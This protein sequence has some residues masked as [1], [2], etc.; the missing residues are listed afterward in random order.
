[1]QDLTS[2]DINVGLRFSRTALAH[3]VAEL[4]VARE[5]ATVARGTHE[6]LLGAGRPHRTKIATLVQWL[7]SPVGSIFFWSCVLSK[8][9]AS[10]DRQPAYSR[11]CKG[12]EQ[13]KRDHKKLTKEHP[14]RTIWSVDDAYPGTW[15][16]GEEEVVD[17]FFE[18]LDYDEHGQ[19]FYFFLLGVNTTFNRQAGR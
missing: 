1:M 6:F 17:Q 12:W 16:R 15:N 14:L 7:A 4:F 19:R 2:Q 3:N 10:R 18:W 13:H 9:K 11:F 8:S 5:W